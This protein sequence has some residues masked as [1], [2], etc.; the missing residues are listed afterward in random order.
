MIKYVSSSFE[1]KK[2]CNLGVALLWNF[3]MQRKLNF[4][5]KR[6]LWKHFPVFRKEKNRDVFNI[7]VETIETDVGQSHNDF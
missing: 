5:L 3:Y 4:N 1:K 2:N 7:L 6:Y